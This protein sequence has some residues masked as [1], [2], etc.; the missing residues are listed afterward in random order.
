MTIFENL[1]SPM[2]KE[3]SFHIHYDPV[4]NFQF[5]FNTRLKVCNFH[6]NSTIC[7]H[8]PFGFLSNAWKRVEQ[9]AKMKQK[10]I[11]CWP[12]RTQYSTA[13]QLL[14]NAW[15]FSWIECSSCALPFLLFIFRKHVRRTYYFMHTH[16][17]NINIRKEN[18]SIC[19]EFYYYSILHSIHSYIW[20]WQETGPGRASQTIYIYYTILKRSFNVILLVWILVFVL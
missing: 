5:Q 4:S 14:L 3:Q 16:N 12:C 15:K 2:K 19:I 7:I 17:K 18:H 6:G 1:Y 20:I 9:N 10:Y 11:V 13:L 8:L